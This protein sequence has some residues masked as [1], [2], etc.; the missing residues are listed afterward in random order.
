MKKITSLLSRIKQCI[1]TL[2]KKHSKDD[3]D[4]NEELAIDYLTRKKLI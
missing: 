1:K 2:R 4:S 3:W